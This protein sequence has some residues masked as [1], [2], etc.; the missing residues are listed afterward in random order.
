MIDVRYTGES[1]VK[2]VGNPSFIRDVALYLLVYY[3]FYIRLEG[4]FETQNVK[5]S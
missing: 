2:R 3:K 5:V 4:L 1:T